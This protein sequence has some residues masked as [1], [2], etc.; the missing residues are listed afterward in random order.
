MRFTT[1]N[2]WVSWNNHPMKGILI[3]SCNF[4]LLYGHPII[5]VLFILQTSVSG[6]GQDFHQDNRPSHRPALELQQ[7]GCPR[8]GPFHHSHLVSPWR[9][10][11]QTKEGKYC[12]KSNHW[13]KKKRNV[14]IRSI[15]RF[16]KIHC[17]LLMSC[18]GKSFIQMP[19]ICDNLR[20]LQAL[21]EAGG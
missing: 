8:V 10:T 6:W 11:Q 3:I 12:N 15:F 13:G 7:T 16:M 19:E 21:S 2:D 17:W 4:R 1:L 20:Y 14:F 18:E 5:T 9:G